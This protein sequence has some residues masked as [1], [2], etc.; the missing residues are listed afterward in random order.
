MKAGLKYFIDASFLSF[1]SQKL[2]MLFFTKELNE[3]LAGGDM[4]S[5]NGW[6]SHKSSTAH[7]FEETKTMEIL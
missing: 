4:S 7:V 1:V 3:D 5:S 2:M 6:G